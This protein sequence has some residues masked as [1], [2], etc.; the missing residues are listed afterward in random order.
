MR[1][2]SSIISP[3]LP[4]TEL[5]NEPEVFDF[6][7]SLPQTFREA[8]KLL[9]SNDSEVDDNILQN[10]IR[11]ATFIRKFH[12]EADTLDDNIRKQLV[13][14]NDPATKVF[15]SSHQPNLFAYGGVFK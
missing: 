13:L 12:S 4:K 6:I 3:S 14:L 5:V 11:L 1:D 2:K 8:E 9:S 15:V 7:K 10:R